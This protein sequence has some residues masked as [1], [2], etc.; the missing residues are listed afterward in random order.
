[1]AEVQVWYESQQ[2]GLGGE[3][4]T[5]ISRV[6]DRLTKTPLIYQKVHGDVRRAIVHRFP[7][8]I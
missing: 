7:Y 6:V 4:T 5:E 1:M 2:S 3:F 8:L